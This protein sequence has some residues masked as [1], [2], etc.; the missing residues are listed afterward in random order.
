[1]FATANM[2]TDGSKLIW[3]DAFYYRLKQTETNHKND[4]KSILEKD[5]NVL[6]FHQKI[7]I[8]PMEGRS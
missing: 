6:T 8:K 2:R 5:Q 3:F 1:M 7:S 4:L